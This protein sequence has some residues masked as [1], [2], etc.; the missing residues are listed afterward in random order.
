MSQI[1]YKSKGP[2][3][4]RGPTGEN[5]PT[6][7]DISNI[8][9]IPSIYINRNESVEKSKIFTIPTRNLV[10]VYGE[11][12]NDL[13]DEEKSTKAEVIVPKK[14]RPKKN[15]IHT[16]VESINDSSDEEKSTRDDTNLPKLKKVLDPELSEMDIVL[17]L[18]SIW[19]SRIGSYVNK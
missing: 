2:T 6:H 4:E 11:P 7:N 5:G 13:S 19:G 8:S 14:V 15:L 10:R 17:Q 12:I 16:W 3:G 1:A 9:S 18:K